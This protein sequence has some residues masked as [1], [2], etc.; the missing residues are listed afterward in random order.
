M[1]ICGDDPGARQI[2]KDSYVTYGLG[3]S[4]SW[5]AKGL[6]SDGQGYRFSVEHDGQLIGEFAVLLSGKH[7]VCNALAAI[8]VSSLL[9][10]PTEKVQQALTSFKGVHRRIELK[11]GKKDITVIDDYAHH[12]AEIRATLQA[13]RE[14]YDHRRLVCIF[15]PHTYSRTR[16]LMNEFTRCFEMADEVLITDIYPARE[17]DPGDVKAEHLAQSLVHSSHSYVG[18]LNNAV[19]YLMDRLRPGDVLLTLGAGDIDQVGDEILRR[20]EGK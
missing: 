3:E 16:L 20:L 9:N 5:R 7:N 19:T 12:P 11:G 14:K 1:V 2:L 6:R 15:Q 8:A 17:Q 13:V 4:V 10:V 18:D